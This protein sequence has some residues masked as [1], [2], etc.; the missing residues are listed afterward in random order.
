MGSAGDVAQRGVEQDDLVMPL[1]DFGA[2]LHGTA[3][4][5][6]ATAEQISKAFKSSGF[7]YLQNHGIPED[8]VSLA[9]AQSADFFKRPQD[10]KDGLRW[11]T[12]DANRG[13]V[14][15][16]R[17][18]VTQSDDPDVI[19][20]L[21]ASNPD[22]K[23]SMEIGREGVEGKPNQWPAHLDEAGA[24]FTRDMQRFFLTLKDLHVNVMRAI[25]LGMGM[26]EHFFDSYTDGGDNTLRLLHYPPVKKS[27]W[28]DNPNQVRAGEHSDY[29]SIT[30]LFQDDIGGLEVK[31]P[32]GTW[33]RATPIPGTI[34]VNAGDLL[35]RWSNDQ[36]KS[37][38]HRVI[39]PP[40][41][42][43]DL[44]DEDPDAMVPARY[45][46]AYFCN[47]NFDRWIEALPGTWEE[48][49]KKYKGINSG[50]YLVMRLAAT[51]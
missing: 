13:Y 24:A 2:F 4:A 10:Q 25:A 3:A 6:Q 40:P 8:Q 49:G 26:E 12:P 18:K 51:Y 5:K 15:W 17:E 19:A 43:E 34:V 14:T 37:T 7:L 27:V 35:Q 42:N 16:G 50:D 33:V 36:I 38:N 1:I 48:T 41:K 21:R 45:S 46:I 44:T 20:K 31:S 29:G 28:R 39:Q 22:L 23:E 30:L 32:K 9:F 11:T 47:P